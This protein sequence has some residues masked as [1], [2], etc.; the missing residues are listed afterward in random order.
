MVL[1]SSCSQ[2]YD[3]CL[4][5]YAAQRRQKYKDD[6]SLGIRRLNCFRLYVPEWSRFSVRT[7]ENGGHWQYPTEAHHKNTFRDPNKEALGN[8]INTQMRH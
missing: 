4:P 2:C 1:D 6:V 7:D 8:G 5:D 3:F